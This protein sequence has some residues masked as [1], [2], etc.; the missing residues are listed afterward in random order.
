VKNKDLFIK[1]GPAEVRHPMLLNLNLDA[2]ASGYNAL[3]AQGMLAA[4]AHIL[5]SMV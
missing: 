5:L 3:P 1:S 2:L 4:L